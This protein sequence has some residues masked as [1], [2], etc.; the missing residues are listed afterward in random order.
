MWRIYLFL[1]GF[2]VIAI[3]PDIERITV[4]RIL[5]GILCLI[6][7]VEFL[8]LLRPGTNRKIMS[9]DDSLP[10]GWPHDFK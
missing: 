3:W 9:G 10:G 4:G 7:I 8:K 5:G 6:L 2:L 1:F